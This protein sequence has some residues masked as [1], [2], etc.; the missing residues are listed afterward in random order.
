M[1]TWLANFF[2]LGLFVQAVTHVAELM[3]VGVLAVL[4]AAVI[5]Y[6]FPSLRRIA[7]E[8]AIVAMVA[9]LVYGKGVYDERQVCQARELE[10]EQARQARNLAQ[11]ELSAEDIKQRIAELEEQRRQDQE[12]LDAY[13]QAEKGRADTRCGFTP[14]DLSKRR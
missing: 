2:G 8:L 1:L 4:A 10:A 7:I 13:E 5:G 14:D 9:T 12:R 11:G 6:F 3:I